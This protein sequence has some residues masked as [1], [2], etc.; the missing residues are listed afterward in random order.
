MKQMFTFLCAIM[1]IISAN[2]APQSNSKALLK[3]KLANTQT[4]RMPKKQEQEKRTTFTWGQNRL[5]KSAF[6]S[7]FPSTRNARR[8]PR[9]AS[10]NVTIAGYTAK[11]KLGENPASNTSYYLLETADE[12]MSFYFS[13]YTAEGKHDIE[14]GKT[15][16]LDDMDKSK[17]EWDDEFWNEHYYTEATFT[18]T[19][20]ENYDVHISA[21]VTDEDGN[22]YILNYD[23][24]PYTLTGNT[25]T[26]NIEN[27]MRFG[28]MSDK[29]WMLKGENDNYIVQFCY[30]SD[31]AN[32][33]AGNFS[34]DD[35]D[36]YTSYIKI[37]TGKAEEEPVWKALKMLEASFQVTETDQ[38]IDAKGTILAADGNTYHV[39]MFF[40]KP[41][42]ESKVSITA[43]NLMV[44]DASFDWFGDVSLSA[45]DDK[46][47]VNLSIYPE[48]LGEKMAGTY[49][50]GKDDTEAV[51]MS[52]KGDGSKPEFIEIYS[53]QFTI[54][55]DDGNIRV[56]G[57]MLGY[58]N[59]EYT[60]DLSYLK[61][62]ATRQQTLTFPAINLFLSNFY[63]DAIGYN[64]DKTQYI[65]ITAK[66]PKNISGTYR[67]E[68][69]VKNNNYVVTDIVGEER[70]EFSCVDANLNVEY[71]ENTKI[72]H[73][74][75]TLLCQNEEDPTDI[76]EFTID[77]TA[78][79]PKPYSLDNNTADFKENFVVYELDTDHI[80][81]NVVYLS[82]MNEN[83]A[84]VLLELWVDDNA[85]TLTPGTYPISDSHLPQTVSMSHGIDE[86]GSI[87]EKTF[88]GFLDSEG[89]LIDTWF[90]VS[91]TVTVA[92]DG[93]VTIDAVN[94]NDK[95]VQ[96]VIKTTITGISDATTEKAARSGA[97]KYLKKGR[98]FIEKNG[99]RF[100]AQGIGVK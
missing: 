17:S 90:L 57:T 69:L 42:A 19:R 99:Q 8:T 64:A 41:Q 55:Y 12:S 16:T 83:K 40:V 72:A 27:S 100:N 97:A 71:D 96:C 30:F 6:S 38:R 78:I 22:T 2:A 32:S 84:V 53:G 60:L 37:N 15:Y 18:K 91:G 56:T 54:T 73:I 47:A 25:V 95:K 51:V 14:W 82:A 65:S 89:T 86:S 92:E 11:V 9:R 63:W 88:A 33:L 36:F 87:T 62:I 46:H 52:Y 76:P 35:I 44:A 43:T 61:P 5:L 58:N 26:L 3:R 85:T 94:S 67:I 75:G 49:T 77:L 23:E 59:V 21:T 31:D 81:D 24:D 7:T 29:S 20:G 66:R 48:G 13:I 70:N 79:V 10:T 93:V 80:E 68:D 34:G 1:M 28:Y 98:L 45:F 39:T 50:I 4:T 74:T